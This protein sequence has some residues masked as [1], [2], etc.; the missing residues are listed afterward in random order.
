MP[1]YEYP[2]LRQ[3]LVGA[4]C[5]SLG[6]SGLS[7]IDRSGRNNH[8]TLT[9]MAGQSNWSPSGGGVALNLDGTND[10][11]SLNRL[12]YIEGQSRLSVSMWVSFV[13]VPSVYYGLFSY[14]APAA[15]NND[16]LFGYQLNAFIIQVNNGTD[17]S[18][19]WSATVTGM[20]HFLFTFDGT[21]TTSTDRVALFINGQEIA[22]TGSYS[23]PATIAGSASHLGAIG[24]YTPS[25]SNW[26]M[27]GQFD[28]IRLYNRALTLSEIR[29]LASRRG[30]G[31]SPLP[32][33]GG[34]LP[35]K[36]SVNVGGTWRAADA[37][38]RTGSGWRLGIP[39]VNV[40][41]TFR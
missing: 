21:K 36:L 6:A 16:I 28:D 3:G 31:L 20:N 8:G 14:G 33:R 40:G 24:S 19:S 2:S 17:G 11:V 34:G 37:Y 25:I 38:V 12:Q 39:Y 4:W 27:P 5:P 22:Y 41:G 15:F 9:N 7:L 10:Y 32:D 18:N 13:Q 35:R 30:I 23:Y 26:Y 1:R 29:L